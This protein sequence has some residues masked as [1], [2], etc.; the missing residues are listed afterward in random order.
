MPVGGRPGPA[1]WP[2][3][4]PAT[5]WSRSTAS[6]SADDLDALTRP[7]SDHPGQPVTVVVDRDG[8]PTDAHGDPG[9]RPDRA[10]GRVPRPRRAP[11]PTGSSGSAWVPRSSRSARCRPWPHRRGARAVSPGRR[12][13]A[14]PPVLAV[15]RP[16]QRFHQVTSAKAANQ[17]AAD[18]TRALS[19][20][21]VGT[22]GH[23]RHPRRASATSCY[24]PDL[25]QHLRRDL[26]PVPHAAARRGARGHR[27]L[28]EDP[29]RPPRVLYHADVAKLMP[30]TW[31]FVAVPGRARLA[32]SLLTDILHPMANPFG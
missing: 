9:Q 21:G 2:A 27:R 23:R 14:W 31:A 24:H 17:A 4:G 15:A 10:R 18:G 32:T 22:D 19:I 26:Q 1:Q 12:S 3:S 16:C 25:D 30:F 28:R 7:S 20:V 13:S 29:H 5:S 11:P 6:P 8:H